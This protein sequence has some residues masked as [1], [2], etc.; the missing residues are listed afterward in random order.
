MRNMIGTVSWACLCLYNLSFAFPCLL[1]CL[2]P[3]LYQAQRQRMVIVQSAGL[4]EM[5]GVLTM[6][7]VRGIPMP[8]TGQENASLS[9]Q[10]SLE[11]AL[12]LVQPV[13]PAIVSVR[14]QILVLAF[15]ARKVSTV[16]LLDYEIML[17]LNTILSLLKALD[18]I[19][20]Y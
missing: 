5:I 4:Q 6:G 13:S 12:L 10:E 15:S 11:F 18:Y 16:L 1:P 19:L 20:P 2:V 17:F 3:G 9:E 14:Y 8:I 7:G